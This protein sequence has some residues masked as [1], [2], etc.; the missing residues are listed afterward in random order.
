MSVTFHPQIAAVNLGRPRAVH[1]GDG[2][3]PVR[4]GA[5]PGP[6]WQHLCSPGALGCHQASARAGMGQM[7]TQENQLLVLPKADQSFLRTV[8]VTGVENVF[9]ESLR[10][11]FI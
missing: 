8:Q 10:L 7:R 2:K 9:C 1:P 11:I 4:I 5:A 6:L 3:V